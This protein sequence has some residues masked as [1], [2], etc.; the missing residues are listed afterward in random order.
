MSHNLIITFMLRYLLFLLL[1]AEFSHVLAQ[2][3]DKIITATDTAS[4]QLKI[5]LKRS[6]YL[7]W[8]KK[9][10]ENFWHEL[11]AEN[12]RAVVKPGESLF[13]SMKLPDT[14]ENVWVRCV[15][16]GTYRLLEY[17]GRY[18]IFAPDGIHK[19][20][21]KEGGPASKEDASPK[22][23]FIGQMI[24][25]FHDKVDYDFS[26][27]SYHSK[28]LV[29]PLIKYHDEHD[30]PFHDYNKYIETDLHVNFTGGVSRDHYQFNALPGVS[31]G[32][33]GLSPVLGVSLSLSF[34]ELSKRLALSAGILCSYN[35]V[36]DLIIR[37]LGDEIKYFDISYEGI[38]PAIPVMLEYRIF[39]KNS[40]SLMLGTG[41][42]ANKLYQMKGRLKTETAKDQVV[43]TRF[44][45]L[46]TVSGIG[47]WHCSD[48]I[49]KVPVWSESFSFGISYGYDLKQAS[50]D[51]Y[52]FQPI[53]SFLIFTRFSL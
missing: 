47:M 35:Q 38:Y 16:D 36:E 42:K 30:L 43:N 44:D 12:A 7:V 26:L 21:Y 37:P 45:D 17:K 18:Y 41:I 1:F 6:H 53:K 3:Q 34:P 52:S 9:S 8:F 25:I 13:L 48:L 22:N 50:P 11:Y 2:E 5:S 15:F 32:L 28:S 51:V 27:L 20:E 39:E 29:L 24:M 23:K 10:Y 33:D 14:E 40:F 4:V 19:L 49:L 31:V 46:T